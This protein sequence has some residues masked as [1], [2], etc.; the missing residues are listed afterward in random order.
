MIQGSHCRAVGDKKKKHSTSTSVLILCW[1]EKWRRSG[2]VLH[3]L[4]TGK[5]KKREFTHR[6]GFINPS[7]NS[8]LSCRVF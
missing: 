2:L 8:K 4:A 5:L 3:S 1:N 7:P 6:T